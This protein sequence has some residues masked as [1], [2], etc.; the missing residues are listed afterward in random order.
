[1]QKFD[2]VDGCPGAIMLFEMGC[3][4]RGSIANNK[5]IIRKTM[6]KIL[7]NLIE[8]IPRLSK[9]NIFSWA[10]PVISFGDHT[11]SKV[12]TLGLNPSNLEFVKNKKELDG[13]ERRFHT[14]KS[15]GIINWEAIKEKHLQLIQDSCR[16]YFFGNPYVQ[17]FNPLDELIKGTKSSYFDKT[18]QACHLDLVPYATECKWSKLN[19]EQQK[20]LLET[21][22]DTLGILLRE[23]PI[24][25]LIINGNGVVRVLKKVFDVDFKEKIMPDWFLARKGGVGRSYKGIIKKISGVE[26]NRDL[27]VL[28][29]NHNIQ[30]SHGITNKIKKAIGDWIK[31]E[32]E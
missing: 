27:L 24:R 32:A 25:L 17:W 6:S 12:A 1:M 26:L 19:A 7:L 15:L 30:R 4:G 21:C 23:S 14:L 28:G 20:L 2:K 29:F 11:Q 31:K 5:T 8:S 9:A 3:P 22:K 10:A 13:R 16:K 18:N